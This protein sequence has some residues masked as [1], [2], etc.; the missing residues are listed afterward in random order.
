MQVQRNELDFKGQKFYCGIDIHKKNWAVTIATDEIL[1]KTFN[2]NAD[3][4]ALVKFLNRNYPGGTYLAGY[5][6]G[7]FGFNLHRYLKEK[8]IDCQ[9]I[10]A[11]DIPTTHKEKDQKRD[12]LDSRKIARVLRTGESKSIWVPPVCL[13]QDR[14]LLRIRRTLVKDQTR[15]KNRIKAFLQIHGIKYPEVFSN[16]R[17]HWSK[18]FIDWLEE[19]QLKETTGTETLQSLVRNL[20]F[21]RNEILV[22]SRKIRALSLQE[23]YNTAH[24]RLIEIPGIGVLTAMIILTEIGDIHRFKNVDSFRSFIGLIP[25]SHSSGEKEYNGR[26][27]NRGNSHLRYLLVESTWT[28]LRKDPYYLNIYSQYRKR[29]NPNKAVIRTARKLVNHIYYTLKGVTGQKQY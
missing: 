8:G 22:I 14:Q 10:H 19:I 24:S 13:E 26:I 2:Q 12:P 28:A 16:N 5:E 27:T 21:I 20:N 29:M 4:A 7:Y 25:S 17:S 11:A 3:P 23:R 18:R 9:V 15:I 6:S 1:L